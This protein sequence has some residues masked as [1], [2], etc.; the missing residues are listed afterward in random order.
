M[1]ARVLFMSKIFS[2]EIARRRRFVKNEIFFSACSLF[3]ESRFSPNLK[4]FFFKRRF[5]HSFYSLLRNRC[6]FSGH[7]S[8]F[9]SRLKMSRTTFSRKLSFGLLP[10]FY[11]SV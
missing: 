1:C 9:N 8:S 10:G 5:S 11:R 7:S 3:Q 2:Y 6:I 4:Y